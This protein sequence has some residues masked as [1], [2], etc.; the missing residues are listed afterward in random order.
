M[1]IAKVKGEAPIAGGATTVPGQPYTIFHPTL[2]PNI[3]GIVKICP[4]GQTTA[5]AML[6]AL[7][8]SGGSCAPTNGAERASGAQTGTLDDGRDIWGI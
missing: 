4:A 7:G 8:Y 2:I 6:T 3:N 5:S 1:A